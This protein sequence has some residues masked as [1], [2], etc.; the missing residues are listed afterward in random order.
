[1][2]N[3][4]I[5]Y[6]S[7]YK[8]QLAEDYTIKTTIKPKKRVD[9]EFITLEM[10]GTLTV[11]SGFAWD[12]PSGP[13]N[14]TVFNMRGSMVHDAFYQLMRNRKVSSRKYKDK[15]DKLFKKM[16]I[17]DGVEKRVAESY[18]TALKLAGKPNTDP[19]NKKRVFRAPLE[20]QLIERDEF[21]RRR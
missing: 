16:C 7:G 13:V 9:T 12:G 10:D 17:E 4:F 5:Q 1:M 20:D 6:R 3:S 11:K 15:A 19:K 21:D 14:D 18:Y 8:Y 2:S